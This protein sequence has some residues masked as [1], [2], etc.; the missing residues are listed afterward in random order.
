M[1]GSAVSGDK[2]DVSDVDA[3]SGAGAATCVK[4][5]SGAGAINGL[6]ASEGQL[7]WHNVKHEMKSRSYVQLF[8]IVTP[9]I[10]SLLMSI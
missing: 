4:V 8:A 7:T 3:V 10:D 6:A 2:T 1:F 9:S 5:T